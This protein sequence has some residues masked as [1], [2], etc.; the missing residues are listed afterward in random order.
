M[1]S[2]RSAIDQT[3]HPEVPPCAVLTNLPR[4][5]RGPGVSIGTMTTVRDDAHWAVYNARQQARAV[6]FLCQ[7][8][9]GAAGVG[10]G[11]TAID[12]G[13]G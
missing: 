6:R 13:R 7:E 4:W 1:N 3:T 10:A 11:R 12:F 8:V 9:L 2:S 5:A